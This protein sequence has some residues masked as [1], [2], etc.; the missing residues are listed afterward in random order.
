MAR[1]NFKTRNQGYQ[2]RKMVYAC[3]C[4]WY[5][6]EGKVRECGSCH[7]EILTHF[8]SYV[9]YRRYKELQLIQSAGQISRLRHHK[10]WSISIINQQGKPIHGC[11]YE[12]DFDYLDKDGVPVVE[13]CKPKSEKALDPVFKLKRRLFKAAYGLDITIIGR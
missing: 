12:S 7:S 8:D 9:E 10:R 5:T 4:G 13:D 6:T 3:V 1:G 11:Y 2:L